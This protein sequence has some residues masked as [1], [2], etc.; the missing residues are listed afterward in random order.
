MKLCTN[1]FKMELSH[2]VLMFYSFLNHNIVINKKQ[3]RSIPIEK[4]ILSRSSLSNQWGTTFST[5]SSLVGIPMPSNS[6]ANRLRHPTRDLFQ[7]DSNPQTDPKI[8]LTPGP[9]STGDGG[10]RG[11]LLSVKKC[12]LK[13][14]ELFL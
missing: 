6:W 1:F 13:C 8:G 5:S 14:F 10:S 9:C 11:V 4:I 3:L 2:L 12:L 7:R